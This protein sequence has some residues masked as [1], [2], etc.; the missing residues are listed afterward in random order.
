[1]HFFEKKFAWLF[2]FSK[3]CGIIVSDYEKHD[4]CYFPD[5]GPHSLILVDSYTTPMNW[6]YSSP[7]RNGH[8]GVQIT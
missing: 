4:D 2:C 3:I 7:H 6:S 5:R 1:M 8:H